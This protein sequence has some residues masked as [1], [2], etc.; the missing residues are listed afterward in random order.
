MSAVSTELLPEPVSYNSVSY[1]LDT[2]KATM[3]R[4]EE[5]IFQRGQIIGMRRAGMS[6]AAI[7]TELAITKS[8]VR[9]WC[10]RWEETGN[11][12]DEARC[13]RPRKTSPA[14][15]R[16][17]LESATQSPLQTAVAIRN[18]LQ[19]QVSAGTVRN[20]LHEAGIHH[21]TPAVKGRLTDQHR[22]ARLEFAQQHIDDGL[23]YWGRVIFSD[24]KTFASNTHGR[25]HCWRRDNT[26]YER[27]NIYEE[28]RS[29]HVTCNVWGWIHLHGVGELTEIR[30]RF[31]A[32][33]Y[34]E[35]LEEV[36][37]PSVRAMALPYPERI[38]FMQVYI[39]SSP[40]SLLF[41]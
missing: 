39:F 8:T 13:G 17:I 31:T 14:D 19:L 22:A 6:I 37:V 35:I 16:S 21:R 27:Q 28:G 18:E 4:Q 25:L 2:T 30:G 23:D 1:S 26:R 36:M 20:R 34:I 24:E 40:V 12:T 10:Q 7:S 11:V 9:R 38:I 33:Q 29:G 41:G 15:N 3:N 32:E 5:K